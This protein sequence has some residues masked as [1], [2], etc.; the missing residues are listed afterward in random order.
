MRREDVRVGKQLTE[1]I[2]RLQLKNEELLKLKAKEEDIM[3]K[4]NF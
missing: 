4:F 2:M 3:N 1:I